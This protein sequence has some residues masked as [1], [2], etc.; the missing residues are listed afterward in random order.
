MPKTKKKKVKARQSKSK[1][2]FAVIFAMI[3]GILFFLLTRSSNTPRIGTTNLS[4]TETETK[5]VEVVYKCD[6]DKSISATFLEKEVD[7]RLS[8]GRQMILPQVISADG[9]RYANDNESTVFWSTGSGAFIEEDN[10]TTYGNC[11]EE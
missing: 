10:Q 3:L 4:P 6:H 2:S 8:D 5:N 11:V 1:I 7:L 9:A